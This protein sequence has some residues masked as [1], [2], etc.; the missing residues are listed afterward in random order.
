MFGNEELVSALGVFHGLVIILVSIHGT[1]FHIVFC[2]GRY[3]IRRVAVLVAKQNIVD[4]VIMYGGWMKIK[5]GAFYR[6]SVCK[7]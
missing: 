7:L 2:D 5:M 6:S 4:V 1:I 3:S